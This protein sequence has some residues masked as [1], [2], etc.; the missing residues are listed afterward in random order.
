ML[1]GYV[2]AAPVAFVNQAAP[3]QSLSFMQCLPQR[4]KHKPRMCRGTEAPADN[5]AEKKHQ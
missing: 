4:I 3:M 2:F 5:P 1:N